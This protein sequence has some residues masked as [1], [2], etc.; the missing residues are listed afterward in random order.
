M[1]DPS[2]EFDPSRATLRR[3]NGWLRNN[4]KYLRYWGDF[5]RSAASD[6]G[7]DHTQPVRAP[8]WPTSLEPRQHVLD[9][10]C[11]NGRDSVYFAEQGHRVTALDGTAAGAAADPPTGRTST[12]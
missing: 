6:A 3:L 9:V 1:P 2:F 8:G 12:R 11:G 5:Y 7:A 4:R 10:G